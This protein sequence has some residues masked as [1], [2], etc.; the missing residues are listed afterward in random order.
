MVSG[1]P[2][3]KK[4]RKAMKAKSK[5]RRNKANIRT[6][7]DTDDGIYQ[8]RNLKQLIDRPRALMGKVDGAYERRGKVKKER[9]ILRK[10]QREM[11]E[12]SN[13][14]TEMKYTSYEESG[15]SLIT[16]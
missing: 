2:E 10:K 16:F 3:K 13:S 14:V 8:T 7:G 4:N 12:I 6:R 9:R 1:Y 15:H 5:M 11:L